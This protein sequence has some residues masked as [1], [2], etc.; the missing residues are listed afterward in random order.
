MLKQGLTRIISHLVSL[1]FTH[2]EVV[3]LGVGEVQS[4]DAGGR[5]HR[6]ALGQL[7]PG[8]LL[9]LHQPPHGELLGVVRLDGVAGSWSDARVFDLQQ[10]FTLQTLSSK[11]RRIY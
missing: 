10:V 9:H 4:G 7:Y 1:Y 2:G 8:L 11:Q 3:R 5:Q 6:Q